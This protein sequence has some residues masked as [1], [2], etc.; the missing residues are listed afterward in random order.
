M[1]RSEFTEYLN[2]KGRL[3][4]DGAIGTELPKHVKGGGEAVGMPPELYCVD[5]LYAVSALHR[6][7]F[8]AGSDIVY[9]DTFGAN[10]KKLAKFGKKPEDIIPAAVAAAKREA[11]AM[12]GLCALDIGPTAELIE[13]MGYMTYEEAYDIFREMVTLG[14][15]AG[16]DLIVIETM[17][18]IYEMKAAV[19]A[20]VENTSLPVIAT[21]TFEENG[22]T[23]TGVSAQSA[24]VI[25][26]GLG[27]SAVGV[28]CSLGPEKL[29]PVVK[30][31]LDSV[32]I[33]IAVKPNAGMPVN[34]EYSVT[35]ADFAKSMTAFADMGVAVIGGCCGT[36]PEYISAL[37]GALSEK[38]I[39]ARE[40]KEHG[41]RVCTARSVTPLSD[42]CEVGNSLTASNEEIKNALIS[43]DYET[44]V[45][46]SYDDM[47]CDIIA[48]DFGYEGVD[49]VSALKN[50]IKQLNTSAAAPYLIISNNICAIE[51]ALAAAVGICAVKTELSASETDA[52]FK[53]YGAVYYNKEI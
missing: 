47:G 31:M 5:S 53:K 44:V 49:E 27:V 9:T 51:T 25:L 26:E 32:N 23:F 6:A 41:A 16:A 3:I 33:T 15:N 34:G 13:P 17:S 30:T 45:D 48:L 46:Y 29:A 1:K 36:S 4:L 50:V 35:P 43:G 10:R 22:R 40:I 24:A 38:A 12:G 21:M 39:A 11:V 52:V 37:A 8:E 19:S 14:E 18:D 7:Y 20:A 2:K 28:N 42:I